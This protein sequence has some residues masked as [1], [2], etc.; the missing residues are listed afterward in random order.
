MTTDAETATVHEHHW[1]WSWA[2]L[3]VVA[4]IFFLLPISF[5]FYFAYDDLLMTAIF[6]GLGT[7]L[8]LAGVSIWVHEG[9][10][11]TPLLAGV[12]NVGLPIFILS[13]IFIFLSLFSSYWMM[14]LG[15]ESWPPE[16]TPHISNTIPLVMT[17]ILVSSS[18][19]AH[20]AEEKLE[21]GDLSGFNKW[22][23]YSIILGSVFL[24]LSLYEWSNLINEGFIPATNAYSSAFYT[25]TGF[26]ASHVLLGLGAFIAVL[27]PALSGRTNKTFVSCVSV[28]WHFVDIVWFFVASQIY[29]W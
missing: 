7:V 8:L 18:V 9:L 6:A 11:Q 21:H 26:H 24:G 12:A 16:G 13:E 2:P 20:M 19:T 1:E 27:I 4:G 5:G 17:V 22:W 23:I 10:T 3:L 15:M 14:R 25:I 29:F 28:Y